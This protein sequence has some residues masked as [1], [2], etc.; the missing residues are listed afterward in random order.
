VE[1][2]GGERHIYGTLPGVADETRVIGRLPFTVETPLDAG[3]TYEFAVRERNLR[4]FDPQSGERVDR[5]KARAAV[6][7]WPF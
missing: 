5:A 3:E 1:H 7:S 6:A 2:L 4:F